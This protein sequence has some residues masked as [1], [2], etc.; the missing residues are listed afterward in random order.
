MARASP[1]PT[2]KILF[3]SPNNLPESFNYVVTDGNGG[4]AT[5]LITINV[6]AAVSATPQIAASGGQATITFHGIP[7]FSVILE[8]SDSTSGPW[9]PLTTNSFGNDGLFQFIDLNAT[10]P[11]AFYR[12]QQN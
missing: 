5:N 11:S 12:L 2:G 9:V 4:F 3:T 8:K 7:G 6:T 1:S 10:N